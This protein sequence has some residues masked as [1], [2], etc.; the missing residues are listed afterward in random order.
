VFWRKVEKDL[1]SDHDVD[2]A[3]AKLRAVS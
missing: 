3:L 1:P 2:L